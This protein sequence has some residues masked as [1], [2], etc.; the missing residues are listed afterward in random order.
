[1]V[2]QRTA[3]L[4]S[5]LVACGCSSANV[6]AGNRNAWPGRDQGGYQNLPIR[7][8]EPPIDVEHTAARAGTLD[9]LTPSVAARVRARIGLVGQGQHLRR[10]GSGNLDAWP[11]RDHGL[12]E[13]LPILYDD[14]G[15]EVEH[16]HARG[17]TLDSLA[18]SLARSVHVRIGAATTE[19]A[20]HILWS[21][22]EAQQVAD[23]INGMW[24]AL[25]SAIAACPKP[26][27]LLADWLVDYTAWSTFYS[28]TSSWGFWWNA[29]ELNS[30]TDTANAWRT[31][32]S[33]ACGTAGLPPGGPSSALDSL[34]NFVTD[35]KWV[36]GI[37]LAGTALWFAW[38]WLVELRKKNPRRRYRRRSDG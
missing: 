17:A 1:M 31:K 26:F 29:S 11:G 21:P 22:S 9:F 15:I 13:N 27:A 19:L 4:E 20:P 30:W 37:G 14:P 3:T 6:G 18:P 33:Q 2:R 7:F 28:Q 16:T 25:E 24:V 10:I 36:V 32:V 23:D 38:P 35:A 12:Y 5:L 8:P 34:E